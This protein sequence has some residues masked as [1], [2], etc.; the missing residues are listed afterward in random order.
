LAGTP[1]ELRAKGICHMFAL[2]KI[3]SIGNIFSAPRNS[4]KIRKDKA[5]CQQE[6]ENSL[7]ATLVSLDGWIDDVKVVYLSIKNEDFSLVDGQIAFR[8]D[9]RA[10]QQ[11]FEDEW[12]SYR[13][14]LQPESTPHEL[15]FG[16]WVFRSDINGNS[17][18]SGNEWG[19]AWLHFGY[20]WFENKQGRPDLS[21]I[22]LIL[23][24][25]VEAIEELHRELLNQEI[26]TTHYQRWQTVALMRGLGF[27][28][29][30]HEEGD[31]FRSPGLVKKIHEGWTPSTDGSRLTGF[32]DLGNPTSP[33]Y[34]RRYV[35]A[36]QFK[37]PGEYDNVLAWQS[38][39][40]T[41]GQLFHP[42]AL[43]SLE[44][45]ERTR[46]EW[47]KEA[48]ERFLKANKA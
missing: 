43:S 40:S 3:P 46:E 20:T 16:I 33:H 8:G 48:C 26:H 27:I 7:S 1:C 28:H 32:E 31:T 6:G 12:Y 18:D 11:I 24:K 37:G 22:P 17:P 13:I 36:F 29:H 9:T 42:I 14:V 23:D 44:D 45:W 47:T 41:P 2:I 25:T 30:R 21:R 15:D 38:S 39:N 34:G 19:G 10:T 4:D 5:V 35:T